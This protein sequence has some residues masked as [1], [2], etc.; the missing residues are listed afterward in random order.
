MGRAERIVVALRALGEA[1]Q[2]PTLTQG[3]DAVAPSGQ[4]LVRIAL[5]PDVPDQDVPGRLE[6]MVQRHRQLDH[7]QR[8]AQVPARHRHGIDHL[9]PQLIGQLLQ[10]GRGQAPRVGGNL[11]SVEQG[12]I[13]HETGSV[14]DAKIALDL[15]YMIEG[16]AEHQ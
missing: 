10:L 6:H 2:A 11:N 8:R 3:A 7:A 12:G 4:D 9:G 14:S 13:R 1:R 16:G 5:M 15:L